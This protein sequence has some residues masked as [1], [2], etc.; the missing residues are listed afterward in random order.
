MTLFQQSGG[1]QSMGGI[2]IFGFSHG[3]SHHPAILGTHDDLETPKYVF[4]WIHILNPHR[5]TGLHWTSLDFSDSPTHP[6]V[7]VLN[8]SPS[9]PRPQNCP[10]RRGSRVSRVSRVRDFDLCFLDWGSG[11]MIYIIYIYIND[12]IIP[13]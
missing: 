3:N 2:G 8:K 12:W 7:A 9:R 11:N 5:F 4:F 13:Y 10:L 6:A 1:F